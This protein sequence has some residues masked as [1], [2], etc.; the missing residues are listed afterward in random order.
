MCVQNRNGQIDFPEFLELF[1]D[2]LL[3]L[4]AILQYLEMHP[5]KGQPKQQKL[6]E[7]GPFSHM[8]LC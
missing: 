3:D 6:V 8:E 5:R 7:V 2:E 1:K 4:H